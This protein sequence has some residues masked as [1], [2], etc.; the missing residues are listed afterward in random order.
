MRSRD[1]PRGQTEFQ[2]I[3]DDP[4]RFNR[5]ST[6]RDCARTFAPFASRPSRTPCHAASLQEGLQDHRREVVCGDSG[7][8]VPGD[9][10]FF[11]A[12][13]VSRKR[14][15]C[16]CLV[17]VVDRPHRN[18]FPARDGDGCSLGIRGVLR[19][20]LLSPKHGDLAGTRAR[21]LP[22]LALSSPSACK[23]EVTV[24]RARH[25]S[26]ARTVIF[27]RFSDV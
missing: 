22:K 2:A 27:F 23:V 18:D 1:R 10:G 6:R 17:H 4:G 8:V 25:I 21:H 26:W 9:D 13:F 24:K 11:G 3:P 5:S 19:N 15:A 14:G 16:E 12:R 7:R 20:D